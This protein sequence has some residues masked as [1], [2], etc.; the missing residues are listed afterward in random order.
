[1]LLSVLSVMAILL[2]RESR[3]GSFRRAMTNLSPGTS[4]RNRQEGAG[5]L[6][7]L[8]PPSDARTV[9]PAPPYHDLCW[10]APFP[11]AGNLL[12]STQWEL[13]VLAG[14]TLRLT[15][16]RTSFRMSDVHVQPVLITRIPNLRDVI[17]SSGLGWTVA[18]LPPMPY[19]QASLGSETAARSLRVR[20]QVILYDPELA[21][22]VSGAGRSERNVPTV[23]VRRDLHG[24]P[25]VGQNLLPLAV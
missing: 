23:G 3:T 20:G 17:L 5:D 14:S 15:G 4:P 21:G 16:N 8:L 9:P 13:V 7:P 12:M 22:L 1:M 18:V 24:A 11:A 2:L 10:M 25:T 6:C 19:V